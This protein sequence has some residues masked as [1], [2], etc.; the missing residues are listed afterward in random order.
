MKP[1]LESYRIE[2]AENLLAFWAWQHFKG[3]KVELGAGYCGES[4]LL[5]FTGGSSYKPFCFKLKTN[6]KETR[7]KK[8]SQE[9]LGGGGG[10]VG[11][12]QRKAAR[13]DLL[14]TDRFNER[15]IRF[16]LGVFMPPEAYGADKPLTQGSIAKALGFKMSRASQI[17][18][19][20][21]RLV[22]VEMFTPVLER[23]AT[24]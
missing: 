22:V 2:R 19:E 24:H 12:K 9:P 16:L 4:V 10:F 1:G 15:Q 8:G 21:I 17:R 23:K 18:A 13:V 5:A 6:A 11:E 7:G 3:A 14:L 20:A